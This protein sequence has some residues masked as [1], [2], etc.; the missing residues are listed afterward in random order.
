MNRKRGRKVE[1]GMQERES[2]GGRGG[3]EGRE[4]KRVRE[5]G[6]DMGV[7]REFKGKVRGERE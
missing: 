6:E 5:V 1:E 3:E 7:R 2:M 4:R